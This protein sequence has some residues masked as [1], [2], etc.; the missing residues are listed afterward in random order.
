MYQMYGKREGA[1]HEF[2][3][4]SFD[5]A[6]GI[7]IRADG[8]IYA[9]MSYMSYGASLMGYKMYGDV[10]KCM[11]DVPVTTIDC[12]R[13]RRTVEDKLALI[14]PKM[15]HF[16]FAKT[17]G[18]AIKI[19]IRMARAITG[20]QYILYNGYHGWHDEV[21]SNLHSDVKIFESEGLIDQFSHQLKWDLSDLKEQN[22][23]EVAALVIEPNR[24]ESLDEQKIH[25]IKKICDKN[26]IELVLDCITVGFRQEPIQIDCMTVLGKTL[27]NGYPISVVMMPERFGDLEYKTFISSTFFTDRAGYVAAGCFLNEWS[28]NVV[29]LVRNI[30]IRYKECIMDVSDKVGVEVEFSGDNNAL[31]KW[32]AESFD[33]QHYIYC[34]LE[35]R[36]LACDAFYP[37]IDHSNFDFKDFELCVEKSFTESI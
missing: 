34:M 6:A 12:R 26:G 14:W 19:A 4:T 24:W 25:D 30:G 2:W 9:D 1:Y 22:L 32:K 11:I 13:E 28:P 21:I 15:C 5:S 7:Y 23:N 3:P 20:R 27:G 33:M 35:N 29:S 36:I 18:E 8:R 16:K 10:L 37:S 31:V 17:G